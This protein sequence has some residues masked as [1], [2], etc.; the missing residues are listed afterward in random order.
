MLARH[1][2]LW[3]VLCLSQAQDHS[4]LSIHRFLSSVDTG[5]LG[6]EQQAPGRQTADQGST[7][8]KLKEDAAKRKKQPDTASDLGLEKNKDL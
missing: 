8:V 1:G 5:S 3:M 4:P 7:R 6:K 2:A